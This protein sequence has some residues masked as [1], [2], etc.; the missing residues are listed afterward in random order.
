MDLYALLL[1]GHIAFAIVWLGSGVMLQVL[2]N[3]FD[4]ADD[5][6]AIEKIFQ[7]TAKLSNTL[8]MPSGLLVLATGVLLI[9]DGTWSF[10]TLWV[11]LGLI[12]FAFTFLMGS[13]WLGPQSHRI[14]GVIER[15]GGMNPQAQALIKRM[16]VVAR[17]D[18]TVLFLVVF[19]MTVKPT[20]GDTGALVLMA[21]VLIAAILFFGMRARAVEIE[22]PRPGPTAPA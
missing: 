21:A 22:G 17:I 18:T 10:S 16:L 1:F 15:Q 7:S 9:I 11:I 12:G 20:G 3:Q 2:A 13:L 4:R 14:A 6:V 8:F 5:D 19:D